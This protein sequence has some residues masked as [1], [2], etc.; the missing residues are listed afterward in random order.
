MIIPALLLAALQGPA[1]QAPVDGF[2]ALTY[3]SPS[4]AVMPYR[5][6]IPD[7]AAR[8]GPLPVVIYLHGGGGAGRDNLRQLS[9]GNVAGTRLWVRS[10]IQRRFPAFV[11]APQLDGDGQWGN[12]G[13][14]Q[15]TPDAALALEVLDQVARDFAIDQ[16]RVYLVGQSRGGRGVWD[17]VSKRPG[18]FAA[19]VPVC[20]D[21]NVDRV[22]A[23]SAVPIWAFHGA[24]DDV[25]PVDG[26]RAMVAALRAAGSQVRYTEYA[27][28]GHN[29]W[30]RA[31]AESELPAWLFSQRRGQ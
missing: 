23:A 7:A 3:R 18:L 31:F 9:T 22:V 26:S 30:N 21:G 5:L 6:F 29:V 13:S 25:V 1:P 11:L 27:D 14:T 12:A 19:A 2:V 20:G 16:R 15:L 8:T 24:L 17:L 28:A 4:G 10:D